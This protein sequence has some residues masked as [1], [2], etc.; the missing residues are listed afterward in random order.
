MDPFTIM[1]GFSLVAAVG[2]MLK[3]V[4]TNMLKRDR[5]AAATQAV[6]SDQFL[7]SH[8]VAKTVVLAGYDEACLL[9]EDEDCQLLGHH[10]EQVLAQHNVELSDFQAKHQ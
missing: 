7:G 5:L 9:P 3:P 2:K 8:I 10:L 4:V 1:I 6:V